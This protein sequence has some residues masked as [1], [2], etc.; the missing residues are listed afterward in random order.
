LLISEIFFSIEGE[1]EFQGLPCI[2]VRTAGCNLSCSY[3]DSPG[4]RSFSSGRE[5]AI[6]DILT[7]I[8]KY[9]CSLICITGGEPLLQKDINPLLEILIKNNYQ[10]L[11]ETNG[12]R[13]VADLP[14]GIIKIIDVKTPSSGQAENFYRKNL[15]FLEGKDHLKYIIG[16]REDFDFTLDFIAKN[17]LEEKINIVQPV[18]GKLAVN[19]L[20]GWVL[21]CG[22]KIR[23]QIQLHKLAGLP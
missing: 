4:S 16:C 7:I 23:V 11:L 5:L 12:S 18:Y 19:D 6:T 8:K 9:A 17:H 2:F 21:D 20:A 15:L 14:A 22:K 10:I 3:C 13:S 1:T